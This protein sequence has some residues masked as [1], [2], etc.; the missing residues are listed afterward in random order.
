MTQRH[1]ERVEIREQELGRL[2]GGAQGLGL[3][4]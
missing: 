2:L 4:V 3:V 1:L